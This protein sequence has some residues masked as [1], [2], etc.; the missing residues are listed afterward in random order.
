MLVPLGLILAAAVA[1]QTMADGPAKDAMLFAGHPFTALIVACLIVLFW[2][3][4]V[5]GAP[6]AVISTI[7]SRALEP[8]GVMVL[9]I[10]AGAAYKEVLIEIG[11]GAA[12][13]RGGHLGAGLGAGVRLR[14]R[15]V[16]AR[17]AGIGD[18]GDGD[19]GGARRAADRRRA[20][21]AEPDRAG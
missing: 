3:R 1:G 12:D 2:L 13:H 15:G 7:M 21:F 14:A 20:A 5:I 17:R 10:G 19:G 11:R 16:R 9:I 8:A 4:V 6:L 18:G